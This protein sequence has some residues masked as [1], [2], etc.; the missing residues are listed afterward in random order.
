MSCTCI[1]DMEETLAAKNAQLDV[2]FNLRGL[3]VPMFS[4]TKRNPRLRTKLPLIVPIFCPF[5]GKRYVRP[6][7]GARKP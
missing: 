1:D 7:T 5:C 2:A 4:M 3:T 6:S